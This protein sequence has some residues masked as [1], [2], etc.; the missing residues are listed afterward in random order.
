MKN[1]ENSPNKNQTEENQENSSNKNQVRN[2]SLLR[3]KS[4]NN[5]SLLFIR[6]L[7]LD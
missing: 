5:K 1:L 7:M 6:R 2:F 4:K 3:K